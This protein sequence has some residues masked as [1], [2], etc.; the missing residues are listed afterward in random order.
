MDKVKCIRLHMER[1]ITAMCGDG[2]NDAGALKAAHTG[3]SLSDADSSV[4]AHFSSNVRSITSCVE[5]LKEARCSLDVSFASYRYLIMYGE[6]LAFI[7]MAQYLFKVSISQ[8]AYILIDGS[9]VPLSWALTMALPATKLVETRPTARLLGYETV[10]SVVGQIVINVIFMAAAI[11]MLLKQGFY[12]CRAFDD[13]NIDLS[14]WWELADNYEASVTSIVMIFQ[15]FHAAG[16]LNIGWKYRQG[17]VKN[18]RFLAVYG[19]LNFL[20]AFITLADPNAL[21][22]LF[23]INCGTPDAL[24]SLG[25]NIEFEAPST[26]YSAFGHNVMPQYF[27]VMILVLMTLNLVAVLAWEG[28]VIQGAVRKWATKKWKKERLDYRF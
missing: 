6:I 5:L 1:G 9:T 25:Y 27:R 12:K 26:Y 15:I 3:I 28:I 19:V 21:G 14:R 20:V 22:C 11:L 18:W 4:V 24:R 16:A 17:F 13:T 2:G 8:A 10:L 23:R 7:G